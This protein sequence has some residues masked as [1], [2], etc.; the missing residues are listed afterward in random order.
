MF[1]STLPARR[2]TRLRLKR[3]AGLGRKSFR[4]TLP[5]GGRRHIGGVGCCHGNGCF[6]PR[7]RTEGDARRA[8]IIAKRC[9]IVSIH[10]PAR[11]ATAGLSRPHC[12]WRE[13]FRSTL[14]HGG[15]RVAEVVR[16]QA[17]SAVSIH[18]PRTEGDH[19]EQQARRDAGGV[20]CFGPRS[21]TEGDTSLHRWRNSR[22][23]FGVSIHA[24]A[25]RATPPVEAERV[26][27]DAFGFDPRSRTEG[28]IASFGAGRYSRT[29]CR[30]FDPCSRTEGDGSADRGQ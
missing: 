21:R 8:Y 16:D 27:T 7:S 11:R 28:D 30:G 10:A 14:P 18:A 2:A 22:R 4:S 15:R 1:R 20:Q 26:V 24:P 6:D 9:I 25:R 5:H 12:R 17:I 29:W 19:P 3:C 13:R 23:D